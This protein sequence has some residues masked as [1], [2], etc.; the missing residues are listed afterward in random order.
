MDKKMKKQILGVL[1]VEEQKALTQV[2]SG[3][4]SDEE[5]KEVWDYIS[6]I[7]EK[8]KELTGRRWLEGIDKN[9]LVQSGIGLLTVLLILN[10][11]KTDIL[12]SKSLGIAQK[13]IGR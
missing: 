2:V 12:T 5:R 7:D 1:D 13:M 4:L 8:R 10:Y 6:F 11:E 3:T 9:I